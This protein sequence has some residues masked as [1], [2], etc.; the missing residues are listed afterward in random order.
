M[1]SYCKTLFIFQ[2]QKDFPND[3]KFNS[4]P[5]KVRIKFVPT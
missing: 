2:K 3:H 1:V 4:Y 5:V